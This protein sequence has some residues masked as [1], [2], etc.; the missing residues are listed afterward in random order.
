[1]QSRD[2]DPADEYDPAT[3]NLA[4]T[5]G[6]VHDYFEMRYRLA[7]ETRFPNWRCGNQF[8][9]LRDATHIPAVKPPGG[10]SGSA[11]TGAS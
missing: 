11:T 9:A 2:H 5:E 1:M 4:G 8:R 7:Q 10:V 6:D 3:S